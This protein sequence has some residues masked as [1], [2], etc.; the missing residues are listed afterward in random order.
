[1]KNKKLALKVDNLRHVSDHGVSVEFGETQ[2]KNWI[3]G[4]RIPATG[5]YSFKAGKSTLEVIRFNEVT[6]TD[7]T[8]ASSGRDWNVR[9]L[10]YLGRDGVKFTFREGQGSEIFSALMSSIFG[11]ALPSFFSPRFGSEQDGLRTWYKAN[12]WALFGIAGLRAKGLA[13]QASF[14]ENAVKSAESGLYY[15]KTELDRFDKSD[16][17]GGLAY[18]K[19]RYGDLNESA[20]QELIENRENLDNAKAGI[21]DANKAEKLGAFTNSSYN[22][23][24]GK[25]DV[26]KVFF[27]SVNARYS[28]PVKSPN[29]SATLD[30]QSIRLSSGIVCPFDATQALAWLKGDL[31]TLR[32][33]YGELERYELSTPDAKAWVGVKCGCHWIDARNL[34]PEFADLLTPK[35]TVTV[36]EGRVESVFDNDPTADN[37]A[38]FARAVETLETK[39]KALET[40]RADRLK[41]Q[42]GI[43]KDCAQKL[44]NKD[45]ARQA[46]LDG[47][48]K[49]EMRVETAK[50]ERKANADAF[51][52][53]SVEQLNKNAAI[54]I[55]SL[56]SITVL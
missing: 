25:Y 6:L 5:N 46:I 31:K 56:K 28:H 18:A 44:A 45:Q 38:F 14:L 12:G 17:A 53:A 32:A 54:L 1:M 10:H 50:A 40:D 26:K 8:F 24:T 47:L 20:K 2:L 36:L 52:G 30:G 21:L 35:H 22:Y 4:F 16:L 55:N 9:S 41:G 37:S 43:I 11:Q 19:K 42:L 27:P 23:E 48:T 29:Y 33:S 51:L 39:R 15:G 3:D 49:Q 13:T 7:A 34:S